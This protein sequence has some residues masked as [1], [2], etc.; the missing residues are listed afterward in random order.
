MIV[1]LE[2]GGSVRRV[3]VEPAAAEGYYVVRVAGQQVEADARLLQPGVLSLLLDGIS[4]RCILDST[5]DGASLSI[6][7]RAVSYQVNDPRSLR[8][9]RSRADTQHGARPLKASMPGRVVRL[10][11]E[12]GDA[13]AAQQGILVIEAM[14]MLNELFAPKAGRVI[15]LRVSAGETVATGQVLAVIE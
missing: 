3:E 9:R 8:A 2:F 5:S 14:K 12:E 15:E 7:G 11:V 13:V 6:D 1:H 10:M 4:Y